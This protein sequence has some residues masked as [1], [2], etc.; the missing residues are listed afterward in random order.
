M[1]LAAAP[2]RGSTRVN[3]ADCPGRVLAEE[4]VAH[5]DV[6]GFASSSMD[7]Y[8][9]RAADV[10][11][12]PTGLSVVG[13][14]MAGDDPAGLVV[15]PGEAVRIM[16]GAVVP[17]GADAVCMVEHTSS[18]ADG[19]VLVEEA[20]PRG[21]NVRHPGEDVTAGSVVFGPGT[22]LGPA[23]VGVLASLGVTDVAVVRPPRV[24]VV[25]TGDELVEGPGRLGPGKLRDSNRPALLAQLA[26]DGFEA[27]DLGRVPDDPAALAA[28]LSVAA[29]ECDA[30]LTS[31][32]VSVGDRDIV[33]AV[34]STM[35]GAEARWSQVAVRPAKPFGFCRLPPTGAPLFGL[36]GNPVSA[37]VSYELFA[38]PALRRMAGHGRLYRTAVPARAPKALPRVPDG[39]VYLLRATLQ[40]TPEG[41][42]VALIEGQGSHQL[43]A[44]AHAN[45]LV[46][47]PDGHGVPAGALVETWV[48]GPEL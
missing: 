13:S 35:Q 12:A 42:E 41:F 22:L 45:C 37:M 38:R 34:L 43:R 33:K 2:P 8:A 32:G 5:E 24:G 1:V 39:R 27:F 10:E 36:P 23:H 31:G 44:L 11:V 18:D 46:V 30:V 40:A 26:A 48:L 19:R 14:L 17:L 15:G 3:I 16:T 47:L 20:V 21:A 29:T 4:V 9:L 25:S 28:L 7:G 6:P